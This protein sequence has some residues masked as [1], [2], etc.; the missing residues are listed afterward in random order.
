MVIQLKGGYSESVVI[1]VSHESCGPQSDHNLHPSI[2]Q[3]QSRLPIQLLALVLGCQAK[4]ANL[5]NPGKLNFQ[6]LLISIKGLSQMPTEAQEVMAKGSHHLTAHFPQPKGWDSPISWDRTSISPKIL[7]FSSHQMLTFPVSPATT[8]RLW[9]RPTQ[10]HPLR[11]AVR[12][13]SPLYTNAKIPQHTP[14]YFC[15]STVWTK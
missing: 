10:T 5:I 2:T 11:S 9:P 8:A 15:C 6:Y 7:T 12:L 3:Q 13:K 14:S 1:W 4:V